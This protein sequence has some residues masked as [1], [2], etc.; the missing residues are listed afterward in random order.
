MAPQRRMLP[1][2]GAGVGL[3]YLLSSNVGFSSFPKPASRQE[4][5]HVAECGSEASRRGA[6]SLAVGAGLSIGQAA[7]AAELVCEDQERLQG[8]TCNGKP[9]G[10]GIVGDFARDKVAASS[11]TGTPANPSSFWDFTGFKDG[12]EVSLS[13]FKS[14]ATVVVNVASG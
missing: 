1:L 8:C 7:E 6:L 12:K 10:P 9:I 13:Q 4:G 14:K 11:F 2:L 5:Q 3:Q